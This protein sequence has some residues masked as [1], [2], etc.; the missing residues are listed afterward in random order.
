MKVIREKKKLIVLVAVIVLAVLI[1]VGVAVNATGSS[2]VAKSVTFSDNMDGYYVYFRAVDAAGNKGDW[3][4]AQRIWID[5]TSPIIT[6]KQDSVEVE[7]GK[8]ND[9]ETYFN[10][11]ENGSADITS[12]TFID[13]SNS[14]KVVENT[15]ELAVG[16]HE[17]EATVEK[18]NGA[19][20]SASVL[21]VIAV[22][23]FTLT[24]ISN[25][26]AYSTITGVKTVEFPEQDPTL[27]NKL[28]T[29]WYYD[30]AT[31][32]LASVGDNLTQNTTL[33]AGWRSYILNRAGW[34]SFEI[35]D[36]IPS[37]PFNSA[38][39]LKWVGGTEHTNVAPASV[40]TY[41][42]SSSIKSIEILN[43][44]D[45]FGSVNTYNGGAGGNKV[46]GKES[47]FVVDN[48]FYTEGNIVYMRAPDHNIDGDIVYKDSTLIFNVAFIK[49]KV[50][51]ADGSTEI[52][53][54][55]VKVYIDI[56]CLAEGTEITLADR[57]TKTI[58]NIT[59]NDNLL[60]WD[61]DKAQFATAKPLW[62]Q[63]TKIAQS[64]NLLKFDNGAELKTIHQHRIM[65]KEMGKFTYPMTDETPIGTTTF[66]DD[67]IEAKLISKEV[68][69]E[70]V[71][72]Y[73]IITD[74][75]MNLF[76]NGILTS[77]RLSN[78][79][80]IKDMR[81]V[82]DNRELLTNEDYPSM[83]EEYFKGLRMA[84]QPKVANRDNDVK[85]FEDWEGYVKNLIHNA[86]PR[87]EDVKK[88]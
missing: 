4:D 71:A 32:Q 53:G 82:K 60:V 85:F 76:A 66:T 88:G 41:N 14:D 28:F 61:F 29:G 36:Y 34:T 20:A 74:Y 49:V 67:G 55:G 47:L 38:P 39:Y 22:A 77:C 48:W 81:Y 83:P 15:N 64:Y 25:G 12:V 84:E 3:S 19:K 7:E 62:I 75:H 6:A 2:G 86:V 65:N 79:Y 69:E 1:G 30:S 51:F 33:Y 73:N 11:D 43:P 9:L 72:Y 50:H 87:D 58:E 26:S 63:K 78:L 16:N 68:V 57:T 21:I 56:S 80:P 10:I 42:G 23:G 17:I 44:N 35:G 5:T 24:F 45:M 13:K 18:A 27:T 31:T 46:T 40:W 70:Q 59:Y 52:D 8:S 54:I 37:E